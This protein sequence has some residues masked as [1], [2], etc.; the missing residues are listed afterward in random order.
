MVEGTPFY[1][2]VTNRHLVT[3]VVGLVL[4][5]ILKVFFDYWRTKSWS[6]AMLT[7]TGG[8]PSSH[9]ALVVA[10]ML[11]IGFYEGFS[12][13]LFAV[14]ATLALV[15]MHDAFGIRRAAGKQA[16]AINFLFSRLE[17]QG[18]KLDTKLK[19]LLGHSPLEVMAGALLGIIVAVS[20]YWIFPVHN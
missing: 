12:T 5:Q 11:S 13:P 6:R 4:A 7:S 2:I 10:L 16:E 1:D 19:E 3:G 15:V 18:I 9:S 20:A 17:K 14:A 8:M